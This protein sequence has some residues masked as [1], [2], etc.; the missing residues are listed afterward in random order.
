MGNWPNSL[1]CPFSSLA[2]S[3]VSLPGKKFS[4]TQSA[5]QFSCHGLLCR[6]KFFWLAGM[7]NLSLFHI[8]PSFS[9]KSSCLW[10]HSPLQGIFQQLH[11]QV[12]KQLQRDHSLLSCKHWYFKL[13]G[14]DDGVNYFLSGNSILGHMRERASAKKFFPPGK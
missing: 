8:K 12:S 10:N 9:I 5:L 6:T 7:Y 14:W 3:I 4:Q 1:L 11:Q 2:I 13:P